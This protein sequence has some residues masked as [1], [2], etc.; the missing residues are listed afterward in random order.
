MAQI[1]HFCYRIDETQN[2]PRRR[3][4]GSGQGDT[5]QQEKGITVHAACSMERCAAKRSATAA[6]HA[7]WDRYGHTEGAKNW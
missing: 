1:G 3:C 4:F 7:L 5:Q 2:L 6:N